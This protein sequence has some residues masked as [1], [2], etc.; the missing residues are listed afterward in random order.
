M[1]SQSNQEKNREE[2]ARLKREGAL[3]MGDYV[4]VAEGKLQL[5]TPSEQEALEFLYE[6]KLTH[7]YFVQVGDEEAVYEID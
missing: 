1:S 6:S 3:K 5:S 4:V 7:T 2:Y